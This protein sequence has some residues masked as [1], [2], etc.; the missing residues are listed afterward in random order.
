MNIEQLK[1]ALDLATLLEAQIENAHG[2][3]RH[4]DWVLNNSRCLR[5]ELHERLQ[6]AESQKLRQFKHQHQ[7]T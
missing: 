5:E 6:L 4:N 3:N 2:G 1:K 7:K